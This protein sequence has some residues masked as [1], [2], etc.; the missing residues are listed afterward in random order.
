M[1]R[2]MV[3]PRGEAFGD[4]AADPSRRADYESR[5][6]R[7]AP[8]AL[9]SRAQTASFRQFRASAKPAAVSQKATAVG[10]AFLHESTFRLY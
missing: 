2:E 9:G 10:Y 3:A 5:F 1:E 7:H 4:L 6:S 8:P